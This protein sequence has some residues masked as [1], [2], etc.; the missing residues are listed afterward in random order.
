[1]KKVLCLALAIV[2]A[3]ASACVFSSEDV[4]KD[5]SKDISDVSEEIAVTP[6]PV[7]DIDRIY[8][9]TDTDIVLEEYRSCNIRIVDIYENVYEDVG[10]EIKV[11]GNST[12]SG[13]KKP[14]NF[15][16]SGKT[17]IL[18]LGKGKK[19]CLLANCYEK[20]LFRNEMVFA[21]ARKT[22]LA[23]TPDSRFVDVYLNDVLLGNYLLCEAVE[24]GETRVDIDTDNN[25]FLLERD[26]REEEGTVYFNSP[27]LGIRFAVNDPEEITQEQ[28][29]YLKQF[30]TKAENALASRNYAE[31]Q[32]YFDIESMVDF[33]IILEYFKQVDITVGSTRFYIKDGKIY[34]GP[35]WDFDLTMGNCLDTYYLDYNNYYG[36]GLSYESI[37]CN[38]DWFYQLNKCEEFKTVRNN[39]FLEL[40]QKIVGLYSE[41]GEGES[42][43]DNVLEAYGSSFE[44]NYTDA[45]WQIDRVYSTLERVPDKTYLEN[46]EYLRNWLKQRNSWLIKEW[47]LSKEAYV[48]PR[49][50]AGIKLSGIYS[51]GLSEGVTPEECEKMFI[52]DVTVTS[53]HA[54]VGTGSTVKNQG[55]TY[56]F[57]VKG[58]VSGNGK[59]DANDYNTLLSAI[60]GSVT[61]DG[62]YFLAADINEDGALTNEDYELLR[63]SVWNK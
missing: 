27:V 40:Q 56:L 44:R 15:K 62:A 10:S 32:K 5:V 20:T 49:S 36:S 45:G 25:E 13:E 60:S 38:V 3:F 43:I 37:Y 24:A 11:R 26:V 19:W 55:F 35:V 7:Y 61:L 22:V 17:D 16:L 2:C 33:Y 31:I 23:Y 63:Q 18:G 47:N 6:A 8:I 57:V 52:H 51:N 54:F 4:S 21:F 53:P 58:D 14:Y 28:L 12:S 30:L 29:S 34:G 1:M 46:V 42:Y 39:R 50:G 48:I 41:T 9:E 59:V